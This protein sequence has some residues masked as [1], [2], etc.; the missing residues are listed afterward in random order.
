MI[1]R[2]TILMTIIVMT[3]TSRESKTNHLI[4]QLKNKKTRHVWSKPFPFPLLE[5]RVSFGK[6][7]P[8]VEKSFPTEL[9]S[10]LA[11]IN[12]SSWETVVLFGLAFISKKTD[13][14]ASIFLVLIPI[15]FIRM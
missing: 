1:I 6:R 8:F 2:K 12:L 11:C 10:S 3:I 13:N 5:P 4:C 7:R 9:S 14:L 15:F